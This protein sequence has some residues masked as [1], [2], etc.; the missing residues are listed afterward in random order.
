V[1]REEGGR[2]ALAA[3]GIRVDAVFTASEIR[4]RA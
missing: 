4:N 1:D 2:E 3:E